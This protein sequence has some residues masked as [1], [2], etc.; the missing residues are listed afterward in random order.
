MGANS[1]SDFLKPYICTQCGG[2][3]NRATLICESCGTTFKENAQG[4]RFAVEKPGVHTVQA[5][6]T[7]DREFFLSVGLEEASKYAVKE[8]SKEIASGLV[9]FMQIKAEDNI[10]LH[11]VTM[12]ARLR[13]VEP[14]GYAR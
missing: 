1:P 11:Q 12:K 4:L 2:R 6:L 10:C 5:M 3:V 8:L 9:P 13:V 7:I 14:T